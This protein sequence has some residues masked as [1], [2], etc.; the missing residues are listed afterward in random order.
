MW[1]HPSENLNNQMCMKTMDLI[2]RIYVNLSSNSQ[3]YSHQLT[4][5]LITFCVKGMEIH[6]WMVTGW[7]TD[8]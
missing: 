2:H 4:G 3:G 7:L 1:T 8:D 5:W 6:D